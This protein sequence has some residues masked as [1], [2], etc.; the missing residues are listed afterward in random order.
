MKCSFRD[1][2]D[3]EAS[4]LIPILEMEHNWQ[5]LSPTRIEELKTTTKQ[6]ILVYC[7]WL[8][9]NKKL[10]LAWRIERE[11]CMYYPKLFA[12]ENALH[13]LRNMY[14]MNEDPV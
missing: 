5:W 3:E 8:K 2:G 14:E 10:F 13:F 1:V 6:K 9:D 12:E 7:D 4:L 11:F